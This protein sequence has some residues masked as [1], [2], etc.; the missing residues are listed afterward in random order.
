[1]REVIMIDIANDPIQASDY[2][3]TEDPTKFQSVKTGRGPLLNK[4]QDSVRLTSL[5]RS[6]K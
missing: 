4:W 6:R 2:K 1:M 3:P 5:T